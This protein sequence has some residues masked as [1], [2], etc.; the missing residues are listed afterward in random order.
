MIVK[1]AQNKKWRSP[2]IL[3]TNFLVAI[4]LVLRF[5]NTWIKIINYFKIIDIC[6]YYQ[7]VKVFTE[8]GLKAHH[9]QGME[10][11][12]RDNYICPTEEEYKQMA[13][14]SNT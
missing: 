14:I 9:G 11:Y 2:E 10:L 12:W 1:F 4:F 13:T 6:L 3:D 8:Q 7:A 5:N